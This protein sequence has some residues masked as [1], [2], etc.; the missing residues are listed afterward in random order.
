MADSTL[1]ATIRI[2]GGSVGDT[3]PTLKSRELYLGT[4]GY[5]YANPQTE[6]D[7][8]GSLINAG[9]ANEAKSLATKN[10]TMNDTTNIIRGIKFDTDTLNPTGNNLTVNKS[11]LISTSRI[12]IT[13]T[14]YGTEFPTTGV[15]VGDIFFKI[16]E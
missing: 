4:D 9:T 12:N 15:S 3:L 2:N 11:A 10:A 16:E 7:K 14:L 6:D 5:L 13:T 1:K 8:K